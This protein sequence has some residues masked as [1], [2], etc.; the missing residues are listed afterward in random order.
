MQALK[1]NDDSLICYRI[2][3]DFYY[4]RFKYDVSA[5]FYLLFT[6][7][8]FYRLFRCFT[9]HNFAPNLSPF[10]LQIV[11]MSFHLHISFVHRYSFNFPLF[12]KCI[13]FA[14]YSMHTLHEMELLAL[15]S[16]FI[17]CS[18]AIS[19]IILYKWTFA[20]YYLHFVLHRSAP[21]S[22][23][24]YYLISS[25]YIIWLIRWF[26]T[27]YNSY[28]ISQW[29]Y[30]YSLALLTCTTFV[31]SGSEFFFDVFL[32]FLIFNCN[33]IS[34]VS[35]YHFLTAFF[36]FDFSCFFS[37][38]QQQLV[39]VFYSNYKIQRNG[40]KQWYLLSV[41]IGDIIRDPLLC[42]QLA[43]RI[44]CSRDINKAHG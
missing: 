17:S 14:C 4:I 38:S 31:H 28:A 33:Y 36:Y 30:A 12:C 2:P 13:Q 10:L 25:N 8:F 18:M 35:Y 23:L 37:S 20:I 6:L 26:C 27:Y 9:F 39:V 19:H 7:L 3:L 24:L 5:L 11:R 34:S 1:W 15:S 16:A 29:L 41:F 21:I 40:M 42:K 32:L 43:T 22:S 44:P